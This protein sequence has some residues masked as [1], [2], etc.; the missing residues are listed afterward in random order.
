MTEKEIREYLGVSVAGLNVL[1]IAVEDPHGRAKGPAFGP[2]TRP[3]RLTL[4]LD[5]LLQEQDFGP[6]TITLMG[7]D[8]VAQARELA[9]RNLL[10][11]G[12]ER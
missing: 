7:R 2:V 11:Q 4:R 5:G 10:G 9:W 12:I 8:V 6:D 3:P 1:A